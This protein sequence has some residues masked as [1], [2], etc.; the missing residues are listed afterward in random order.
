MKKTLGIFKTQQSQALDILT[1]LQDILQQGECLGVSIDHNLKQKLQTASQCIADD[2]LRV[3]LIG[4]FSE[5][6]TSIAAAWMEKLDKSTMKISHQESSD[7][8]KL[9]DIDSDLVLIDTPGLF[10]FKEKFSNE[11]NSIEKYKDITKRYVSEAHLVLY[12]MNSTNP[13]KESHK[14]DLVWLF[15]TLNLLSRTVFVLSRFDEV[16]DVEDE[17]EYKEN[18]TIKQKNVSGRLQDL[19][20]LDKKELDE[21]AII[22]VAANPFDKGIDYWL[23]NLEKFKELSR[24]A[25]LQEATSKK[26][27]ANGGH[28]NIVNETKNS[29][30]LDLLHKQL[31]K[32]NEYSK[33]IG[34]D[35]GRLEN[36]R[37]SMAKQMKSMDFQIDEA[38]RN[39]REFVANYFAD[40]ILQ[41]E[42]SSIETFSDFFERNIGSESIMISTRLQNEF[43]RQTEA[44]NIAVEKMKLSFESEINHYNSAVSA[45]GKQG[46]NYLINSK[47]INNTTVLVGRDLIVSGAK[48]LGLELGQLLKFKPY[49]AINLAKGINGTLA[50][51]GFAVEA[52]DSWE[53]AK[54]KE[55]FEKSINK[56]VEELEDKRKELL[57]L[58]NGPDFNQ[59]FFPN[60]L[61]LEENLQ[62]VSEK[63]RDS[64][65]NRKKLEE[66]CNRINAIDGE[67]TVIPG[68]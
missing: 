5:G 64:N 29:I 37:D 32:A 68:R 61:I 52:W 11:T 28:E 36:A 10:G 39:L 60:Y 30:I 35:A 48:T 62:D 9:Y 50:V 43:E 4:G 21:L 8:V 6:K 67:F 46:L 2:K 1:K 59:I 12:V 16:A 26:I 49:G 3:A 14:E 25:L 51:L 66:W 45:L 18:L 22:A 41:A 27:E 63:L 56:M 19:V 17:Q 7:E 42:G 65:E 23:S 13:I 54:R 34:Q 44:V 58:I 57:D 33:S 15:K 38:K 47:A 20:G 31:P 55:E 24:I 53:Q 40:L